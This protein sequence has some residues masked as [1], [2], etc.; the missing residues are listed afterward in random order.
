MYKNKNIIILIILI[1][2]LLIVLYLLRLKEN[3]NNK[4]NNNNYGINRLD[5]VIYINLDDRKDRKKD[6]ENELERMGVK[7]E[8][9]IRFPAVY[10]KLNGHLGCTKSH[11]KVLNIIKKSN[12]K[13]C[14][15]LEDDFKFVFS[16]EKTNKKINNF[17]NKFN[18]NFDAIHLS[19]S[20][21]DKKENVDKDVCRI[22]S[23]VT[24]SGYIVNNNGKFYD[25]LIKDL[26]GSRDKLTDNMKDW[27]NKNPGKKRYQD[28]AALNQH[29]GG[30]QRKSK[31]YM[32]NPPLGKQSGSPST[33]MGQ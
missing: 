12:F 20:Y 11:L 14:L 3:F 16:K 32:F 27:L 5:A 18:N 31:W 21:W 23:V 25:K 19:H 1:I 6:I 8:K 26:E 10:E 24:A 30:L 2:I 9:I 15:I 29:W 33:I 4:N 17:L 7:K 13:N 28:G 22:N